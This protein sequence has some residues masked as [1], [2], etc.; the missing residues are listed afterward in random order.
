[1]QEIDNNP[2]VVETITELKNEVKKMFDTNRADAVQNT[3]KML[4][5]LGSVERL[6]VA[7]HFEEEIEAT[8]QKMHKNILYDQVSNIDADLYTIA[9]G[10]RL[11]RQ[12]GYNI[13]CGNK[14]VHVK[15]SSICLVLLTV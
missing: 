9:L 11:L 10:F 15:N 7:C 3:R 12:H 4:D 14:I 6:G 1:M 8:V 13:S 5:L 2:K